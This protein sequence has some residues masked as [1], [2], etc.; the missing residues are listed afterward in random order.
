[1]E[2]SGVRIG[3]GNTGLPQ[4]PESPYVLLKSWLAVVEGLGMHSLDLLHARTLLVLFEISHAILPAAYISM[5][6]LFR[7]ADI[8]SIDRKELKDKYN[9]TWRG[10]LILDR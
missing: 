6:S 9:D 1:M 8:L 2:V 4:G 5:G 10:I 3:V 7:A